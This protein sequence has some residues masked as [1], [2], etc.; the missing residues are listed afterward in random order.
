MTWNGAKPWQFTL[1]T[2]SP[3]FFMAAGPNWF[4]WQREATAWKATFS[5]RTKRKAGS[6]AIQSNC[7]KALHRRPVLNLAQRFSPLCVCIFL[8]FS[9]SPPLS[10]S[11]PCRL[12][13]FFCSLKSYDSIN[14]TRQYSTTIYKFNCHMTD[15]YS[16]P[17]SDLKLEAVKFTLAGRGME[18]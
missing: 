5:P 3:A 16:R 9:I 15:F 14:L 1:Q 4:G 8:S 2:W 13:L 10:P 11:L 17:H 7:F 6:I 12:C 18:F